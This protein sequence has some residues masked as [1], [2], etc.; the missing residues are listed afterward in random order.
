MGKITVIDLNNGVIVRGEKRTR[1]IGFEVWWITPYG[2]C[3]SIHEAKEKMTEVGAD[4]QLTVKPCPVAIGENR[5][6]YEPVV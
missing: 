6:D 2:L 5:I 1:I 3:E 4:M